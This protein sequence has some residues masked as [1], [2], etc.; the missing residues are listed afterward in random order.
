MD[1]TGKVEAVVIGV[2]GFLGIGEK[3]VAVPFNEIKFADQP[4][5]G[6]VGTVASPTA[7]ANPNAP[8]NTNTNI[9]GGTTT[10]RADASTTAR[11]Y[12]DHAMI[13]LTKDQLNAARSF[14]YA[15]AAGART[16]APAGP[17]PADTARPTDR[18][19]RSASDVQAMQNLKVSLAQA[20]D[21][22]EKQGQGKA[23]DAAFEREG[24]AGHYEIKVLSANGD[25]LVEYY[26]D[27]NSGQVTRTEN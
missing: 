21:T 1:R 2:G 20:I 12:P 27:G 22:A 6:R 13:S 5:G 17:V 10:T 14:A 26:L 15:G 16:A 9:P 18:T 23:V 11:R 7:P 4:G 8:A 25:K 24:N 3:S 19:T